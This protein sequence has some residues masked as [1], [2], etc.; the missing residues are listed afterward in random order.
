MG[1]MDDYFKF[2]DRLKSQILVA[3]EWDG[4]V[5]SNPESAYDA[6]ANTGFLYPLDRVEAAVNESVKRANYDYPDEVDL[7]D[8]I[9]KQIKAI[10]A[11]LDKEAK[12]IAVRADRLGQPL[13]DIPDNYI[14]EVANRFVTREKVNC[15]FIA[16]DRWLPSM[17]EKN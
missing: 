16:P 15:V 13:Q 2:R 9:L 1:T 8:P 12:V 6:Y 10:K 4:H 7:F 3:I 5:S 11:S 14:K 17:I